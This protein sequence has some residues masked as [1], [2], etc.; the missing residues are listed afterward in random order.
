[1]MVRRF[2]GRPSDSRFTWRRSGFTLIEL[3]V[4]IAIIGVLAALLLPAVQRAREAARRTQCLNHIKQLALAC[5][6]YAD[7]YRSFPSGYIEMPGPIFNVPFTPPMN[8]GVQNIYLP[9]GTLE[10]TKTQLIVNDWELYAPWG[11]H[12]LILPQIEQGNIEIDFRRGKDLPDNLQAIKIPIET[13]I[14]PTAPL[15]STRP[16]N[17]GYSNYRGVMGAQPIN[18]STASPPVGDHSAFSSNGMFYQNSGIGFKDVQVDGTANTLLMGDAR[19]GF[20]GDGYSCCAR[21]RNDRLDFDSYWPDVNPSTN[22]KFFSFGSYHD[23]V[24]TFAMAD[25]SGRSIAK[26]IDSDLLR[27]LATRAEG[28]P[29]D[30]EF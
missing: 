21:F 19:F 6:S 8:L 23:E 12:A 24:V 27:R 10:S 4:V 25:A 13:F 20:W 26:N 18:D 29:I 14:C 9:D 30:A 15:P 16:E 11:W 22:L 5:H 17:L 28:L 1:M 3:L 2:A 7:S